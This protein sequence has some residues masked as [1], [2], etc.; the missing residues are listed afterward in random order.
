MTTERL[1]EIIEDAGYETRS[2][3]G[4]SMYGKECVGVDLQDTSSIYFTAEV[5]ASVE[6]KFEREELANIFRDARTDSIG[7]GT[8]VYFTEMNLSKK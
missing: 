8:I 3:S 7:L 4:R 2:Y 5:V 1:V 6:D